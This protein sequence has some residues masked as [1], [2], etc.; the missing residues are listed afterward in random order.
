MGKGLQYLF[1]EGY[2][3]SD[4]LQNPKGLA[5]VAITRILVLNMLGIAR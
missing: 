2:F 5:T 1:L 3:G 4:F